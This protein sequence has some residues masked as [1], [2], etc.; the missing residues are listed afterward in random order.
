[1]NSVLRKTALVCIC[2]AVVDGAHEKTEAAA[3]R[4]LI[5]A[6][7]KTNKKSPIGQVGL[8]DKRQSLTRKCSM[9]EHFADQEAVLSGGCMEARNSRIKVEAS[10][11]ACKSYLATAVLPDLLAADAICAQH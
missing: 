10:A 7:V 8:Q 5:S 1:M 2:I 4:N 9:S 11:P 3:S 6:V